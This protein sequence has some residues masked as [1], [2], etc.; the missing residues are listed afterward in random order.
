MKVFVCIKQIPDSESKI[1]V[2][3]DSN[4]IDSTGIKWVMN[5]YDEFA[6]EES[7]KLRES[8]K[9]TS[10][11][12]LSLGPKA[13]VVETL[14]T[15]LAM[16]ADDAIVIDAP[17]DLD[18][19]ATAKALAG[20]IKAEGEYKFILTGKVSLDDN[21]ASVSQ[22][23]AEHLNIPHSTV[24]SKL[25]LSD[26]IAIVER[27]IEGG[28]REVVQLTLPAV[29]GANKGLNLPR[30]AS[31]PG[32]MKAKKKPVKELTLEMAGASVSDIR[33][34][35]INFQ[36]PPE[37]PPVKILSGDAAS[38]AGELVKLLHEEA[39]VL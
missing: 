30:Y 27:E 26:S 7:I 19:S 14:R 3:S 1:K 31:L 16:G 6:V 2:K 5:P 29:V 37:K 38:Q 25:E 13:R 15:A 21:A 35:H 9:A 8:G 36:L 23:I 18:P 24:I 20:A 10:V 33:V 22:M 32:I 28:T 4:G 39:K 34:R 12:V 17:E 11:T